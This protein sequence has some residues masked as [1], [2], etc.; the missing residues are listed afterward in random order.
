MNANLIVTDYMEAPL[1]LLGWIVNNTLWNTLM[2]T[3]L[4]AVP[5]VAM[6]VSEWFRARREGDDEGNKGKLALNRIETGLYSMV[7]CYAFTCLPLLNVSIN[8]VNTIVRTDGSGNAC[9]VAV[10][11]E[12]E[13]SS[14]TMNSLSGQTA[15]IPLWWAFVH[16]ISKGVT[17]SAVASIPC[18]PD[19]QA[20]A[21]EVDLQEVGDQILKAEIA[22]FQRACYG[23]ARDKLF[24][25]QP[26]IERS[27]AKD[28]AWLGSNHL[29]TTP[30]FYDA[31]YAPR[32]IQGF[33]YV[34]ARDSARSNTGPGQPGYPSCSEWWSDGTQGL[35][36]RLHD[37]VNPSLWTT[38]Q[39]AVGVHD[40]AEEAVIR[41]MVSPKE[42]A[43]NGKTVNPVRGYGDVNLDAGALGRAGAGASH[44]VSGALGAVGGAYMVAKEKAGMDMLK[45][46]LPMVQAALVMAVI[47]C[48]PLIM[49]MSGYSM[50][51]AGTATFG[52]FA[53]WF[54]TFWWELARWL[55]NNLITMLYDGGGSSGGPLDALSGA[56]NLYDK[57]LLVLVERAMFLVL[58]MVWMAV[59]AWAGSN[60]GRGV[61][62][63]LTGGTKGAQAAGDKASGA[64]IGAATKGKVR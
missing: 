40:S 55:S 30:G 37:E 15:S 38:L 14:N 31:F 29:L 13:W 3:G 6:M 52:L 32:P 51:V 48:L 47:I 9:S 12:G 57:S 26:T 34:E 44:V 60:V 7:L 2:A 1:L 59:M 41:R 10:I 35:Y 5:F 53:L 43:A 54:L 8:P 46:A 64:A 25:E 62:S 42:G 22:D 39:A 18:T 19:W 36:K 23:A 4:A 49:V 33:P 28:V 24:R 20:I 63:M 61:D 50:K 56:V 21:T 58:P 11:G 16:V 27:L 17:N 45:M